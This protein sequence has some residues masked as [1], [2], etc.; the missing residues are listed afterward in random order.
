MSDPAGMRLDD[1]LDLAGLT[2]DQ[3]AQQCHAVS[4]QLISVPDFPTARVARGFCSNPEAK[5]LRQH[6]WIVL[7]TDAY[8]PDATVIDPTLWS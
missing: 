4:L 7:G 2:R 5:M 3:A 8:D 6:S 1:L